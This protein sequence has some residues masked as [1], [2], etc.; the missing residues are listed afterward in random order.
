[1]ARCLV[2]L[3]LL[4]ALVGGFV[5]GQQPAEPRSS[6]EDWIGL[7]DPDVH[8]WLDGKA[9]TPASP[10]VGRYLPVGA[11]RMLDTTSGRLYAVNEERWQLAASLDGP[12]PFATV[13]KGPAKEGVELTGRL[14]RPAKWTPQLELHPAGQ[15]KLIDLEGELLREI[16][17]GTPLLVRGVVR[18]RLHRGGTDD[19]P[20]P[21][22]PQWLVWVEVTDLEVRPEPNPTEN[23]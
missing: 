6:Q 12:D 7:T 19:N 10:P 16:P 8:T 5:L 22:P 2:L 17:E 13:E 1:M 18:S 23:R 3:T 14:R 4:A 20:S 9:R 21:F 15:L 11:D